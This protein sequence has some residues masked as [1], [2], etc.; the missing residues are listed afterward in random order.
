MEL[1]TIVAR[2][3][4]VGTEEL[5]PEKGAT[6]EAP[7]ATPEPADPASPVDSSALGCA[8]TNKTA[9]DDASVNRR[10]PLQFATAKARHLKEWLRQTLRM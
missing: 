7:D 4:E 2:R 1:T 9:G 5:E 3:G 10:G 6:S 8:S